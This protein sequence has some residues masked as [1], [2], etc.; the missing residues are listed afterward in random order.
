MAVE[1]AVCALRRA[2]DH[3]RPGRGTRGEAR[4]SSAASAEATAQPQQPAATPATTAAAR[5][6]WLRVAQ[7]ASALIWLLSYDDDNCHRALRAAGQLLLSLA[8]GEEA[9]SLETGTM[10]T[11][12][13]G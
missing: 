8:S 10:Q 4:Y 6:W 9:S 11:M 1:T 12:A 2:L 13:M 3:L 7:W 5:Q